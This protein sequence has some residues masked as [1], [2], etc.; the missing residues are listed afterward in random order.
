MALE[1][2]KSYLVVS[3]K[4]RD[5]LSALFNRKE[6][7][8]GADGAYSIPIGD[9][10]TVWL[11]GDTWI[12]KIKDG[13]R[14]D[15]TMVN[16]SAAA[17]E[18]ETGEGE[19]K[20]LAFF[21]KSADGKPKAL[22]E[23]ERAASP[24]AQSQ[25]SQSESWF[26]PGDGAAV[27]GKLYVVLHFV[28]RKPGDSS[29]WGF[30]GAG[31]QLAQIDNP[32]ADPTSWQIHLKPLPSGI[33]WGNAVLEEGG[34]LYVYGEYPSAGEGFFKHPTVLARISTDKLQN[35]DMESW[36]YWCNQTSGGS[37]GAGSGSSVGSGLWREQA[38]DPQILMADGAPEMTVSRVR[39]MPGFFATY[40][41]AGIGQDIS[42][43]HADKPE[44]PWSK[45]QTAYHAT[46]PSKQSFL[47]GAKAHPELATR[48]GE[49]VITYCRNSPSL[50][51]N[52]DHPEIYLPHA[53][54]V[55][56]EQRQ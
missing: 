15:S 20:P 55:L 43:R 9:N 50:Q 40:I 4:P 44:G 39:G 29:C 2:G 27:G 12:G 32:L 54:T 26:W 7:W 52:V 51:E 5:E 16:N 18:L 23:P 34:F 17:Q 13:R 14:V 11:F 47:Y 10:R 19:Q 49:M 46:L 42:I 28:R 3:S 24:G 33:E 38:Q 22:I 37:A 25:D 21:W 6:G 53:V 31:H 1:T 8:T 30:V 56:I 35:M 41:R 36:Q 48:D 45:P